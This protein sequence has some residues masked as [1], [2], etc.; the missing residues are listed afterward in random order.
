MSAL[1]VL[2]L[3]DQLQRDGPVEWIAELARYADPEEITHEVLAYRGTRA[4]APSLGNMAV[5]STGARGEWDPIALGRLANQLRR[6]WDVLHAWDDPSRRRYRLL[7]RRATP[8]V[9]TA[10]D[11]RSAQL[12]CLDQRNRVLA[13]DPT[14]AGGL[15]E[16]GI[17]STQIVSMPYGV[18]PPATG[19]ESQEVETREAAL[20][21]LG[22]PP[23]T[24]LIVAA[25]PLCRAS[26]FD[27][28]IWRFELLRLLHADARLAIV[29][30]GPDGPWLSRYIRLVSDTAYVRWIDDYE[31]GKT[32]FSHADVYWQM[33]V[34]PAVPYR[35]VAALAHGH[36]IVATD[37]PGHR[38]VISPGETGYLVD[39]ESR[40]EFAYWTD[41]LLI[42][43]P[44]RQRMQETARRET[45]QRF[46]PS[47]AAI[48]Q[49]EIYRAAAAGRPLPQHEGHHGE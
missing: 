31:Q 45:A 14:A 24:K 10:V 12:A 19:H 26:R 48:R 5:A 33:S 49:C 29:A 39:P 20:A 11:V 16:A 4:S 6:P 38:H 9:Y 27:E 15:A 21:K 13:S 43:G 25:G 23:A 7:G 18:E 40:S 8:Q 17:A 3:V 41:R 32:I 1:H 35:L 30:A 28:A 42:D 44:L 22:W 34:V 47:L 46:D 2:H 36:A 37:T